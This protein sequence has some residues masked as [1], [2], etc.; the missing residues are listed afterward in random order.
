MTGRPG[1]LPESTSSWLTPTVASSGSVN[2]LAE[3]I[4]SRIG[5][6]ASP[7]ECHIAIRPCMAATLAS[8]STPVQSPAA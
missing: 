8:S 5:C 7:S 3:T 6:T 1:T 4:R 2:T